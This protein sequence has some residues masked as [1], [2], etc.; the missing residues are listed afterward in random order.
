M[1][2]KRRSRQNSIESLVRKNDEAVESV[3]I[4][5]PVHS[6]A[7]EQLVYAWELRYDPVADPHKKLASYKPNDPEWQKLPL[8]FPGLRIVV[9]AC[10]TKGSAPLCQTVKAA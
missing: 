9:G 6:L 5:P 8:A 7:Q 10:G 1:S 4:L 2:G 3:L